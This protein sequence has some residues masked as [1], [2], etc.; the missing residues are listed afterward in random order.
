MY[1]IPDPGYVL[2]LDLKAFDSVSREFLFK[3]FKASIFGDTFLKM[4]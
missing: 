4:D 2:F 1:R 3:S